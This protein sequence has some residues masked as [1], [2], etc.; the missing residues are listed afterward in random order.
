MNGLLETQLSEKKAEI[1]RLTAELAKR[2]SELSSGKGEG[3][4]K[5]GVY[6]KEKGAGK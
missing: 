2:D 5:S 6:R 3:R 1:L 4:R